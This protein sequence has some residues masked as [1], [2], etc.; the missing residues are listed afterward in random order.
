MTEPHL[1]GFISHRVTQ[2]S[3]SGIR[4]FFDLIAN[5]TDVISLGV[6]EPDIATPWHIREQAIYAIEKGYT[7]YT[8]NAGLPELRH[9]LAKYLE[10]HCGVSYNPESELLVTVGVS[11]GLDLALRAIL[12]PG[13][14]VLVPDPSYVAYVP[15]VTLAGGQAVPIPTSSEYQFKLLPQDVEARLSPKSKALLF[16]YPANPTGTVMSREELSQIAHLAKKHNLLAISD[17][18]YARLV[19][20]GEHT[21]FSSLPHMKE[22]TILLGGFSKAYAMTGWRIGYAA[23]P[24]DLI[25]AMT[26]VHQY[27]M[28]CAPI[29]SQMAALEALKNGEDLVAEMAAE[30]DRRRH[31]I[32]QG[33]RQIGLPCPDPPGAFYAFPSIRPTGL[34][35]EDFAQELLMEEKVAVVPGSAFGTCGEGH[36]RCC[37]AV[38]PTDIEEALNRM[39]RFV[40]RHRYH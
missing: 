36:I 8:S 27:T 32:V 14:E 15:C 7:M 20:E 2:L 25:Q 30:Y 39:A 12:N 29:V 34:S 10:K 6:G 28:L 37:Y 24:A 16:G 19:Y 26:K 4:R 9:E 23:G 18:V 33:L 38:S 13:D 1:D 5:M 35:S 17:E 21:C 22:R 31:L 11:Q 40:S 3:P